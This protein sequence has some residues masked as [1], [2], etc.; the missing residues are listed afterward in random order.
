M[1]W[2]VK[3]REESSLDGKREYLMGRFYGVD[4]P[5]APCCL[6]GYTTMVFSTRDEARTF[7]KDVYGYLKDRPDLKAE[8]F[9]WKI[10]M[11][12]KVTVKVEEAT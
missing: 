7:I 10:P 9:G 3:W 12:V 2:A 6:A 11:P 4:A 8:P 1:A 5:K